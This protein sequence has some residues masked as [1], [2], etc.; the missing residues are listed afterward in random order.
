[1]IICCSKVGHQVKVDKCIVVKAKNIEREQDLERR[2]MKEPDSDQTSTCSFR[3]RR[4]KATG[5]PNPKFER[6]DTPHRTPNNQ[7]QTHHLI[8]P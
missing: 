8:V 5:I 7:T 2:R 3:K 1:M 6:N 4:G